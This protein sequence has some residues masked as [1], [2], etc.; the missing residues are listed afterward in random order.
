[1]NE[2][3]NSSGWTFFTNHGHVLIFISQNC[4]ATLREVAEHVGITERATHMIV[5]D[6]EQAG[7]LSKRRQGRRNYYDINADMPL[8]H[9]LEAHCSIKQ[10][11]DTIVESNN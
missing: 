7:F 2:E 5:S 6:L 1:M 8:R 4:S 11:I 10:I 9:P 3:I